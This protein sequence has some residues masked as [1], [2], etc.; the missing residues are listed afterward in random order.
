MVCCSVGQFVCE[1]AAVCGCC[2]RTLYGLC[3]DTFIMLLHNF[4]RPA[5]LVVCVE[6]AEPDAISTI[7]AVTSCI[8]VVLQCR[9]LLK[10][11]QQ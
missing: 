4:L 6:V 1:A 3:N 2:G 10:V 11:L 5:E 8:S 9:W 7:L